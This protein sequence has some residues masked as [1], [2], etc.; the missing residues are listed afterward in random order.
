[1]AESEIFVMM[2]GFKIAI[3]LS[4][5]V[6]AFVIDIV[7]RDKKHIHGLN[8]MAAAFLLL[9]LLEFFEDMSGI[10]QG[11]MPFLGH[12]LVNSLFKPGLFVLSGLGIL[13]Y[14]RGLCKSAEAC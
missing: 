8:V 14:F 9:T 12:E 2:L 13:W 7:N 1:M 11:F 4:L 6:L 3:F 5:L 10:Y